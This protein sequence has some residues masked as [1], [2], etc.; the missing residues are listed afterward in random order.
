M[1]G[2]VTQE[3]DRKAGR[4]RVTMNG[5]G[6]GISTGTEA[7]GL[8]QDGRF[9]PLESRSFHVI[10]GRSNTSVTT[11]DYA[12]QR[13]ELHAVAYTLLLSRRRQIDDAIALPQDRPVDDLV[14]AALN[15]AAGTLDREADGTYYTS[16]MRRKRAENEGTDDVAP[17]GYRAELVPL[18]FRPAQAEAITSCRMAL[19]RTVAACRGPLLSRRP[20]TAKPT[21]KTA[22]SASK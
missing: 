7:T 8:I 21:S 10:R 4:Y 11:Y 1:T 17:D 14:S 18:R 19:S 16:V 9:K 3:I 5:K 6:I 20:A 13:A 22:S 12:R 15:F 2:T